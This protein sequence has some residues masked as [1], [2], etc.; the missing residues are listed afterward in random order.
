MKQGL[1]GPVLSRIDPDVSFAIPA[2]CMSESGK[3]NLK[4]GYS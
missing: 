3:V 4:P 2:E 1:C